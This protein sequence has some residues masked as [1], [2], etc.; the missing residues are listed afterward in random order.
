MGAEAPL[1]FFHFGISDNNL[2]QRMMLFGCSYDP[3]LAEELLAMITIRQIR[4]KTVKSYD[5]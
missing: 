2:A 1:N 5:E 3:N 4:L